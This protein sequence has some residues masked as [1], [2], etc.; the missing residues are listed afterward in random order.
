VVSVTLLVT[1]APLVPS[2]AAIW[3]RGGN[4]LVVVWPGDTSGVE[5]PR[6]FRLSAYLPRLAFCGVPIF[7]GLGHRSPLLRGGCS[8]CTVAT[9]NSHMGSMGS[10]DAKFA[11]S[12]PP[13]ASSPRSRFS[14]VPFSASE[15]C[16]HHQAFVPD[17]HL[18][19]PNCRRPDLFDGQRSCRRGAYRV[20]ILH[21][22]DTSLGPIRSSSLTSS[23]L[24]G[25][26]YRRVSAR[27]ARG[28]LASRVSTAVHGS[29]SATRWRHV[30]SLDWPTF[31]TDVV[32]AGILIGLAGLT[33]A[34]QPTTGRSTLKCEG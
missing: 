18:D 5:Q 17:L 4:R 14:V 6:R 21:A 3:R 31:F 10:F 19:W 33:Q 28:A 16:G 27:L 11:S 29:H 2:N 24:W 34:M 25:G 30:R 8:R 26:P 20:V 13:H 9:G 1:A 12:L 22:L 7:S 23:C 15:R 32:I